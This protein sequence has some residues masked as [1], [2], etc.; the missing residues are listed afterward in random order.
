[1]RGRWHFVAGGIGLAIVAA[2]LVPWL[3]VRREQ[4]PDGAFTAVTRA[5]LLSS[6]LPAMPGQ[7]S[8]KAVYVTVYKDAASCGTA[9]VEPGWIARDEFSW[10]MARRRAAIKLVAEWDLEKCAL[11][12]LQ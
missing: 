6:L 2:L 1:M 12:V 8:D 9:R 5:R 7:G 11:E 4:S 3:E 10:D